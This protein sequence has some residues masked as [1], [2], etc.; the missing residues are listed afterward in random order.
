MGNHSLMSANKCLMIIAANML[1]GALSGCLLRKVSDERRLAPTYQQSL[2]V[3][4]SRLLT[5][6]GD[7]W[8][9]GSNNKSEYLLKIAHHL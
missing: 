2:L 1:N 3:T 5:L 4:I 9:Q 7:F 6:F 8:V